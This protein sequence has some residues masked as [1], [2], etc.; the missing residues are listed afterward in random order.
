MKR[1]FSFSLALVLAAA[2]EAS[3][4]RGVH[5][6]RLPELRASSATTASKRPVDRGLSA[7]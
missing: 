4:P 2:C 1:S 7:A 6:E 5:A 3:D